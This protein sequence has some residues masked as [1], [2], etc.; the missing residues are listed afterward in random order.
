MNSSKVNLCSKPIFNQSFVLKAGGSFRP[1]PVLAVGSKTRPATPDSVG[2][3]FFIPWCQQ[4]CW[5]KKAE[6]P[7]FFLCVSGRWLNKADSQTSSGVFEVLSWLDSSFRCPPRNALL[8]PA[9]WTMPPLLDLFVTMPILSRAH[10]PK[11]KGGRVC[12]KTGQRQPSHEIKNFTSRSN[13][14][15]MKRV[16][17]KTTTEVL[18]KFPVHLPKKFVVMINLAVPALASRIS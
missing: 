3:F 5:K 17:L 15:K 9:P 4:A 18:H 10:F 13:P 11:T 14:K 16:W 6:R 12:K 8:P 1:S 2:S 7:F